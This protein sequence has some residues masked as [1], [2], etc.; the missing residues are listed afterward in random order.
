V[1]GSE[2]AL[3]SSYRATGYH[4]IAQLAPMSRET[5]AHS[6]EH[7]QKFT[8]IHALFIFPSNS[9]AENDVFSQS[10]SEPPTFEQLEMYLQSEC[11]LCRSSG[12]KYYQVLSARCCDN[13]QIQC[14]D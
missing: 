1:R 13:F 8:D 3:D 2:P 6:V 9:S 10:S 14:H 7:T 11:F 4:E 12:F 5:P